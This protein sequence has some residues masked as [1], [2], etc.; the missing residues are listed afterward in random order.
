MTYHGELVDKDPMVAY[1]L[2]RQNRI[3]HITLL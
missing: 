2:Q 1:S 3:K